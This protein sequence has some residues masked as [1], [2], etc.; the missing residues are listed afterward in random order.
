M[1][2]GQKISLSL[3]VILGLIVIMG[4]YSIW[5][6][7]RIKDGVGDIQS[8]N[9]RAII[10]AKAE[11]EYTG[12]V[13]EIR[14]YIA[15]GDEKY[16]KN[17][18]D[19]LGSVIELEKQLLSI[20]PQGKRADVE[21]LI[22]D[23]EKYKS[24]VVTRLIPVLRE[25][26]KEKTAGNQLRAND[27]SQTS[28]IITRELTPFAQ[29]IQQAL[30]TSVEANS[31]DAI[32]E[33]SQVNQKVSSGIYTAI[34]LSLVALV[35][36]IILSIYLTK[37]ITSPISKITNDIDLM[38][39]GIFT[40]KD[41]PILK[42]RSDEFGHVADSLS[43]MKMNLKALI[44][45]VQEKTELLASYSE[46]LYVS[47]EQSAQASG[48]V[49]DSIMNV[50]AGT[51]KQ[52]K[53]IHTTLAVVEKSATDSKMVASNAQNTVSTSDAATEAA[54]EGEKLITSAQRQ[55]NSI[56][57]TVGSSAQIVEKL[58]ERSKHIGQIV[59]TIT[60]IAGQTNLLAL[61]AAIEAARAGEQ[62][63]GFAV[64]AEEVRK[65]AEQ[66]EDAAKLIAQLIGEI[67]LETDQA[68][69][70]MHS[71]TEEVRIGGKVVADAGIAFQNIIQLVKVITTEVTEIAKSGEDVLASSQEIVEIVREINEVTQD[72]AAQTQT[73]SAATEEQTASMEEIAATSRS[74][75]TMAEEL[76]VAAHKF[77]I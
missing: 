49:A 57:T 68:V 75:T 56:E 39:G 74:L 8:S 1:K 58:G 7:D 42:A 52:A 5:S 16:S 77:K 6:S 25:Q 70:A 18:E 30:H 54:V 37:Q 2:I 35:F 72:T 51:D 64:V 65:L 38:A 33:V 67:Q 34:V 69:A 53:S 61:N 23:T 62:G 32:A 46:E 40:G 3:A 24:G 17:F 13:L 10:S 19:K 20:T 36:G 55:M 71:G 26:Y 45:N 9:A 12:A 43:K 59:D 63:R 28:G 27:L 14:R 21:K 47:A 22:D 76:Q 60:G 15:D 29:A 11:N 31:N 66:S 73:V 48:Q 41:D 50:V 4:I 44:V